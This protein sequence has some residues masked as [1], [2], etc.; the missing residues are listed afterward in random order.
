MN[1]AD[2]VAWLSAHKTQLITML[3]VAAAIFVLLRSVVRLLRFGV[4]LAIGGA[5]G[6]AAAYGLTRLGVESKH[7]LWAAVAVAVA[8]L[9]LGTRRRKSGP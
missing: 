9:L 1:S 7:A 6:A 4:V 5:A 2:L 3:V 8:A